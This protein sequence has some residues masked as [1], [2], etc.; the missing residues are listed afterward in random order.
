MCLLLAPGEQTNNE[1]HSR[2]CVDEPGKTV[3]P[4]YISAMIEKWV[5]FRG[6]TP[7]SGLFDGYDMELDIAVGSVDDDCIARLVAHQRPPE[8]GGV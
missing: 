3:R 1:T 8:R 6:I 7:R 4:S 2:G 5:S